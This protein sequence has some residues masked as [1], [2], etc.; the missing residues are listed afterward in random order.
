MLSMFDRGIFTISLDFELAWGSFDS[1]HDRVWLDYS[2]R[3][4]ESPYA[5]SRM[6]VERL[7]ELF[8]RYGI[9]VTWA[10]V[11]HL[12]LEKCEGHE[13]M[14]NTARYAADP[15]SDARRDPLWYARDLVEKVVAARPRHDVGSHSFSHQ[16]FSSCT[17][18]MAEAEL[19]RC[20][21]LAGAMGLQLRSFVFP[22]NQPG[23]LDLLPRY[24]FT[25]VRAGTPLWFQRLPGGV[26]RKAA[27]VLDA[28]LALPPG[29]GLPR[30]VLPGL[31]EIPASMFLNSM[32]GPRRWL[33]PAARVLKARR[34]LERAA[35]T[36]S[37][38][39]LMSHPVNF[40]VRSDVMFRTLDGILAEA[41]RLRDAGRLCVMTMAD[42]AAHCEAS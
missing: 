32:E 24:G 28:V 19:A 37:I 27:H 36:R 31:W 30:R 13:D 23:H 42:V 18:D 8:E 4:G 22:R 7:L 33:V 17:R 11:G 25:A 15:K 1:G 14:P 6:L 20:V 39:H 2:R 10:V 5:H 21:E 40:Y 26:A 16:M 29:V 3:R 38:F 9:P 34:G 41:A 35:G 12:Y